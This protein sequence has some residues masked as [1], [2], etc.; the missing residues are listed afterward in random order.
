MF[1]K[2]FTRLVDLRLAF[3]LTQATQFPVD[4]HAYTRRV[5]Q[6]GE[7]AAHL[8]ALLFPLCFT[9]G[10]LPLGQRIQ[11]L[12]LGSGKLGRGE[13]AWCA[14]GAGGGSMAQG[15]A[16]GRMSLRRLRTVVGNPTLVC[17]GED[18]C[19]ERA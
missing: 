2:V 1:G 16:T 13:R 18:R 9:G 15:N 8:T 10:L 14:R 3:F 4:L 17:P 5:A 11:F 12:L 6:L 7:R 19:G